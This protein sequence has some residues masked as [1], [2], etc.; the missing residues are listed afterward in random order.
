M[1]E[2]RDIDRELQLEAQIADRDH[3]IEKLYAQI[4][5]HDHSV[6]DLNNAYQSCLDMLGAANQ[7]LEE[8]DAVIATLREK[9]RSVWWRKPAIS[10]A[11]MIGVWTFSHYMGGDNPLS[12]DPETGL[13]WLLGLIT[14]GMVFIGVAA[15]QALDG[16][17]D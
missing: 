4:K 12:R 10:A 6:R 7:S 15:V 9:Q 14:A 5:G 17:H 1:R 3:I 11:A 2:V 16:D 13:M 8:R